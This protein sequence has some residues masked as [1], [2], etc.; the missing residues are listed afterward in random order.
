MYA[1]SP[2]TCITGA[3]IPE[4][5]V[6]S[7]GPGV[8]DSHRPPCRCWELNLGPLEEQQAPLTAVPSLEPPRLWFI[9]VYGKDIRVVEQSSCCE[10]A[11]VRLFANSDAFSLGLQCCA[12]SCVWPHGN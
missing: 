1:C 3:Y 9:S 12:E 8:T 2:T 7:L 11:C 5:G 6:R 4:E 10:C